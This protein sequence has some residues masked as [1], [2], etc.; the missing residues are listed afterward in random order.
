MTKPIAIIV[1]D[2]PQ[3]SQ[4][5][6]IALENDFEVEP[7]A[8]GDVALERLQQEPAPRIILLD[9]NLPRVS[10]GEILAYIRSD[11]RI[12]ETTVLLVTA[13]ERRAETLQNQADFVLL[14][15]VSPMQL[16]QIALRVK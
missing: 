15:P 14:K 1:E 13:D 4:I 11:E 16:Q 10:G 9:V 7:I 12:K 8:D 3:L 6:A 2:D 5:F